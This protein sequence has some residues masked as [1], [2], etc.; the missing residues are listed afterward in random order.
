[1]A[2]TSLWRVNGWLGKLVVY[3]ENP[4]KT[5]N[6]KF[7][8]KADMTEYQTQGLEDVIEYAVNAQKTTARSN[9][10][11]A[12]VMRQFVSGINVNPVTARDSMLNVKREFDKTGG[13]AAYH[14]YQSFAPGEATPEMAH[15]IGVKLAERLWGA[16]YQVLVA[17]HL[18]K[19]NH[20]HNHYIINTVSHIDGKKFHR[21]EKDYYDMQRESDAL[22][23]EYGLSVIEDP[24]R[25]KSKHYAEWQAERSGQPTWRGIIKSDTDAAI[26]QSM[27]ER[28]FFDNLRKMGYAIKVGKDISVRPP[29][30]ERFVRLQ[31]NFGED[32]AIEGIRR[33]ILA[34]TNPER[35]IIPPEIPAKKARY[36][37]TLHK[38]NR[39]TGLRA[40]YFYYL[41]R[42]GVLPK[43]REPNPKQVYF[44]FREDIR[45]MQSMTRE[46]HLMAKHG[47]D[48]YEQLV[49]YKDDVTKQLNELTD[50]RKHLRSQSRSIK[51]DDK[52]QT[53]KTEISELSAQISGLRRE[54]RSCE[55]IKSRSL[56]MKDKIQIAKEA[57]IQEKFKA[58]ELNRDEQFRR[59]R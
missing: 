45:H 10:E 38:V 39:M 43:K 22:C 36:I 14:G 48:T 20:L 16:K 34:Q 37:G 58:K 55:N 35:I 3:V 21:T 56:E 44:L 23:R 7:Y 30:K 49:A 42:M 27:T 31:R 12:P 25:G 54:I 40:L 26:R 15:D 41:Y 6:P 2:T 50:V 13:V 11:A 59:R 4:D 17:T 52:R 28:Q 9:D 33:R 5:E 29:G 47:I 32:Y 53:V 46:I 24:M 18:D 57:G 19:S 51:D 1:M 8:R